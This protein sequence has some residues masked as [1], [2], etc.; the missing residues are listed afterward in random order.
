[1]P[2]RRLGTWLNIRSHGNPRNFRQRKRPG[3]RCIAAE[4]EN[5]LKALY[6]SQRRPLS[7]PVG[8]LM[9]GRRS[10]SGPNDGIS[11]LKPAYGMW[12]EAHALF[13]VGEIV[14]S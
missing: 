3:W 7:S 12:L 14:L 8:S 13:S 5:A 6:I 9:Q 11:P 1:M 10:S 4:E 2:A